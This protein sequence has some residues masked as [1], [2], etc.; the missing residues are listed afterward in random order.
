MAL[1]TIFNNYLLSRHCCSYFWAALKNLGLLFILTLGPKIQTDNFFIIKIELERSQHVRIRYNKKHLRSVNNSDEKSFTKAYIKPP[2]VM[3]NF[4]S[5]LLQFLPSDWVHNSK[6]VP[7]E[8]LGKQICH[9]PL[10]DKQCDQKL[11]IFATLVKRSKS[12]AIFGG[13]I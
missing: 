2:R 11:P 9:L 3:F 10:Y 12:L 6:K 5:H 8:I 13:L 1:W 4:L 7:Y